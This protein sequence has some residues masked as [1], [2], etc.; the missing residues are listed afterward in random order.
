M[1][2]PAGAGAPNT[3]WSSS[4]TETAAETPRQHQVEP[5]LRVTALPR[6]HSGHHFFIFASGFSLHH[7]KQAYKSLRATAGC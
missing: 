6:G 2:L 5:C 1:G 4:E 7:V 3:G